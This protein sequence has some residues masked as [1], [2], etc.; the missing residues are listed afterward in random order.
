MMLGDSS[1]FSG[2]AELTTKEILKRY[3]E[4]AKAPGANGPSPGSSPQ[5]T[6]S[7]SGN[8]QQSAPT[9]QRIDTDPNVWQNESSVRHVGGPTAGMTYGSSQQQTPTSQ[10]YPY[11]LGNPNAPYARGS[12]DSVNGSPKR[13]SLRNSGLQKSGPMGITGA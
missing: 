12:S 11:E 2:S 5:Q 1:L 8:R 10:H 4:H 6:Y 3:N 7:R 9:V 13:G